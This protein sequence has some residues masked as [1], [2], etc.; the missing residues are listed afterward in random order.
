MEHQTNQRPLWFAATSLAR[1]TVTLGLFVLVIM[2]GVG[3]LM[4]GLKAFDWNSTGGVSSGPFKLG[5]GAINE[6][7]IIGLILPSAGS[8]ALIQAVLVANCPQAIS[9]FLFFLY[10]GLLTSLLLSKVVYM[11]SP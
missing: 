3:L 1:W 7:T 11:L 2:T 10:D 8:A 5:L 6:Q 9:A 4:Y